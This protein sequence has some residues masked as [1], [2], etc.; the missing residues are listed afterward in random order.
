MNNRTMICVPIFEKSYDTIL[1]SARKSIEAGADL[2]EL[3][4]DVMNNPNPDN[5]LNIIKEINFP[6]IATNR[7][8]EEGGFFQGTEAERTD[9]LVEAAKHANIIDIELGTEPEYL[10]KIVKVSKS[11]II[12]YHDFNKTPSADFLLE[13]V[14][15]EKKLGDIAKF[16][17][18]PQNISDTL[19]VLEVLS[20]VQNTIG[21]AMGDIGM[22]TRIIAPFFGSP[23]TFASLINKS[24]PG[25]LDIVTT[26]NL[27]DKL[28][29]WR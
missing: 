16:S 21:I 11:T 25:Q 8:V 15:M 3:R 19:I 17:V 23:I 29:N 9:I 24:A 14:R 4:I 20:K 12:S 10:A 26:K 2:L 27:L 5:V 18:M 6:L 1:Q 22:Y 28:R 7:R 13:I